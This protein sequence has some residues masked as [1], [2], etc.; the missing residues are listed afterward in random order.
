VIGISPAKHP[1]AVLL[2]LSVPGVVECWVIV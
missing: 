1:S 2:K